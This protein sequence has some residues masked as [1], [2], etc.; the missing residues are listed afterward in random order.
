MDNI[1][2]EIIRES[3]DE[4]MNLIRKMHDDLMNMEYMDQGCCAYYE[5]DIWAWFREYAGS[6]KTQ[7]RKEQRALARPE[8]DLTYE[9]T[10]TS[11]TYILKEHPGKHIV[12]ENVKTFTMT[13]EFYRVVFNNDVLI[14]IKRN[15]VK[16]FQCL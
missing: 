15:R 10:M 3:T 14:R 12:L 6:L 8:N 1:T 4:L 5:D 13:D 11:I 9:N 16:E 2:R 7:I